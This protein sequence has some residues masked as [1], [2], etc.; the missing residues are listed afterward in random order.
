MKVN[1][2]TIDL[3]KRWEGLELEAYRD[4]VGIWTIGYGHST[5]AGYGPVPGPG[6]TM[7]EAEAEQLLAEGLDRFARKVAPLLTRE[8]TPNQFGAM[9]SL[10][11]NIGVG[12]FSKSTCL[13]RFNAG[14]IDGAAEALTWFNKAGGKVL[15][16][17]VNRREEERTLFLSEP[18]QP[19]PVVPDAEKSL[20]KST[21][22]LAAGGVGVTT[23]GGAL[24]FIG[25]LDPQ[26]QML[27]IGGVLVIVALLAWIVRERIKK[28]AQGW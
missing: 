20:S 21:T 18:A 16:G 14:D 10:A 5:K 19:A 4:P 8:P 15:R 17:L 13:R 11:Y 23:V 2:A 27:L 3:V 22:N 24:G 6:M 9:V 26:A 28:K 7:T 25:Q 1:Q 12:A